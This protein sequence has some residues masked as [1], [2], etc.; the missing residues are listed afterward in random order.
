MRIA[1]VFVLSTVVAVSAWAAYAQPALQVQPTIVTPVLTGSIQHAPINEQ[2][3]LVKSHRF[4]DTWWVHNDSGDIARIFAVKLDGSVI[5]PPFLRDIRIGKVDPKIPKALY[6][7]I[8]VDLAAN[9]DWEDITTDGT[10]LYIA[11]TG[12]NGNARRD[13]GI[14]VVPEPNPMAAERA[15]ALRRISIRYPDQTAYPDPQNW[16]FDCE[17]VFHYRGRLWFLT[18]HRMAGKI[19]IPQTGTKLYSMPT[20]V[21]QGDVNVLE[22]KDS[23]PDMG[24]WVTGASVSPDGRTL[25]VLTHF[26][27]ASVWFIE[28][29]GKSDKLL[30]GK[31]RQVV[32]RDSG[33]CEAVAFDDNDTVIVSNEEGRL[34]SVDMPR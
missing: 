1:P 19:S 3:G 6:Q 17:A 22:K 12:N 15:T 24:G 31:K 26:P 32:I 33:Q 16:Q 9:H 27:K 7:G 10:N 5:Y 21:L 4:K 20:R 25:A 30:Q 28:L 13:L 2:S 8:P 29:D 14:Y 23:L 18:K 34:M 11:D